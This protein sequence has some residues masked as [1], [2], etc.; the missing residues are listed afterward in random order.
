LKQV[1]LEQQ[2][3]FVFRAQTPWHNLFNLHI[4]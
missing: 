2:Q 3:N 1:L 4:E